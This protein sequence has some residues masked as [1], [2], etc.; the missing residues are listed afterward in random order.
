MGLRTIKGSANT[1]PGIPDTLNG[2]LSRYHAH[3]KTKPKPIRKIASKS[4]IA[5]TRA[6]QFIRNSASTTLTTNNTVALPDY[7]DYG[8]LLLLLTFS[9]DSTVNTPAN[10][11]WTLINESINSGGGINDSRI[12]YRWAT[13]TE[14]NNFAVTTAAGTVGYAGTISIRNPIAGS[15]DPQSLRFVEW[16][17]LVDTNNTD[18]LGGS[19]TPAAF[20]LVTDEMTIFGFGAGVPAATAAAPTGANIVFTNGGEGQFYTRISTLRTSVTAALIERQISAGSSTT[21]TPTIVHTTGTTGVITL[22][23]LTSAPAAN[24]TVDATATLSSTATLTAAADLERLATAA[25]SSTATLTAT[26]VVT[27]NA[28]ATLNSTA[29]LTA[30]AVTEKPATATLSST[31]TLTVTADVTRQATATLSSTATLTG[32]ANSTVNATAT[33]SA[34][35]TLTVAATL[36]RFATAALSS[37]ATLTVT[38]V[39]TKLATAS[40]SSTATLTVTAVVT[41]NATA[42]LA[43]TSTLTVTVVRE[44][45]VTISLSATSSLTA[46]TNTEVAA[47]ASLSATATLTVGTITLTRFGTAALNSTA[48]LFALAD[49]LGTTA[50]GYAGW[51]FDP[52]GTIAW[53]GTFAVAGTSNRSGLAVL[54]AT[55][56]LTANG[57]A[58]TPIAVTLVSTATLT[59]NSNM[60]KFST[61]VL[62][63]VATLVA[64]AVTGVSIWIEFVVNNGSWSIA[65]VS[66]NP[67]IETAVNTPLYTQ[68]TPSGSTWVEVPVVPKTWS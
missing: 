30:I 66:S 36:E 65:S 11:E 24:T 12:F 5:L 55:A 16:Q 54:T 25:L 14:S 68:N 18:D 2:F 29:T 53:G 51:G 17:L 19:V 35:A 37:T 33:L 46:N 20:N 21:I 23:T 10:G 63:S 9:K 42:A 7:Y 28:T 38:A 6:P 34:T 58:A 52:W 1:N 57:I 40:L 48:T 67:Y 27:K 49:I 50:T 56:T 26:A 43:A 15:G 61:V 31:A 64:L 4:K 22:F 62:N 59:A 41:K 32:L 60:T 47:T 39:V 45:F 44:T 13:K 8:D 3:R